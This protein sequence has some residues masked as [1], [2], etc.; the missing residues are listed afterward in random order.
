MVNINIKIPD[1]LHKKLKLASIM[2]DLTLKDYIIKS[3]EEKTQNI[4]D[5]K[6]R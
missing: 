1:K 4:K 6:N 5:I 3:L 2:N